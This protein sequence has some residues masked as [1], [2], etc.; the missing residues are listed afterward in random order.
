MNI[1]N[2]RKEW[3]VAVVIAICTGV[4]GDAIWDGL[5]RFA[6]THAGISPPHANLPAIFQLLFFILVALVGVFIGKHL[7]SLKAIAPALTSPK[8]RQ[9]TTFVLEVEG[10]QPLDSE[11]SDWKFFLTNCTARI[12]RRVE[13]YNIKSEIGA[14]ILGF[15]EIPV[16][17]PGQKV[18]L[19]HTV[20]PQRLYGPR[21]A[22]LWDFA[23]DVA[24]ARATTFFWYEIYVE[25]RE[26]DDDSTHDGGFVAVCFDLHSKILKTEG[27]EYYRRDR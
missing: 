20:F 9:S 14:Y 21:T 25:Y 11:N 23:Q 22:T 27:A 16:M 19:R 10:T 8:M 17:Q 24:G 13:L 3:I 6:A 7:E 15:Q 5:K 2:S 18:E 1:P 12:L 26:A 4:V